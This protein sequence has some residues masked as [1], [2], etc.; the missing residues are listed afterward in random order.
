MEIYIESVI[1]DNFVIDFLL[2]SISSKMIRIKPKLYLT[3]LSS[4]L[5]AVISLISPLVSGIFLIFSKILCALIMVILI[6][7]RAKFKEFVLTLLCFLISTAIFGGMCIIFASLF[8]VEYLTNNGAISLKNIPMGLIV[9]L[10]ILIYFILKNV[11]NAFYQQKKLEKFLYQVQLNY[12][13]NKVKISGFLDTGNRL[14]DIQTNK[15]IIL[16]NF[17]TAVKLENSLKLTD[18]LLEKI[19]N[20]KLKNIHQISVKSIANSSKIFVFE[21]DNILIDNKN[22]QNAMLGISL[23]SFKQNLQ[24]D[25]ILSPL[26]FDN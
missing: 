10:L 6:N 12:G 7:P 5:G 4:L 13:T 25:C 15:P 1:F 19:D 24:A 3:I 21:I 17:E 26:V 23:S 8:N 16:I 18:L 9:L 2:L 14:M 11:I 22:I 20:I